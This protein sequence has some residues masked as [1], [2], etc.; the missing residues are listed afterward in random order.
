MLYNPKWEVK[1][2]KTPRFIRWLEKQPADKKYDY[3]NPFNCAYARYLRSYGVIGMVVP[4][5]WVGLWLGIIPIAG[6][7]KPWIENSLHERNFGASLNRA[8]MESPR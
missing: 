8:R 6:R 1:S 7:I 3:S 4:Y 5:A 2:P